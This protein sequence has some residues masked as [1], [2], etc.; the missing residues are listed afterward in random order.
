MDVENKFNR[1]AIEHPKKP[2]KIV[3]KPP[4]HVP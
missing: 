4:K 2:L 3:F 1:D